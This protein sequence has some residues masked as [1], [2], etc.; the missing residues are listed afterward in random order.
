MGV[1]ARYYNFEKVGVALARL[2]LIAAA[3]SAD[4]KETRRDSKEGGTWGEMGREKGR[5]REGVMRVARCG[6]EAPAVW[7]MPMFHVLT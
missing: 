5:E 7:D 1:I 4:R 2:A 3:M 6:E